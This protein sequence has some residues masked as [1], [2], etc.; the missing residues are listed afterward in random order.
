MAVKEIITGAKVNKMRDEAL[1]RKNYNMY[2]SGIAVIKAML[3]TL[4]AVFIGMAVSSAL[5]PTDA[6]IFLIVK[7]D[8][9]N[10]NVYTAVYTVVSG[11]FV[12]L[13][14]VI[15]TMP[16]EVIYVSK[17]DVTEQPQSELM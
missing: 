6:V 14:L 17:E 2:Y 13:A 1:N 4:G 9:I 8:V 11:L 3:I 5:S 7:E 15:P 16:S 10:I 12:L